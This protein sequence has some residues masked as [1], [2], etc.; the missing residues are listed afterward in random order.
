MIRHTTI[1]RASAFAVGCLFSTH[2][3][4][5]FHLMQIEQVIGGVNGDVTAQAIQLRMRS[6]LQT[7]M[8]LGRLIVYDA[9]G[10][11]PIVV[12][13]FPGTVT[14]STGTRVLVASANFAHYTS[15]AVVPNQPMPA[16]IP[17][18]YLAAGSLT[19]EDAI[20]PG[21]VYWR[22]SWG[23]ASYTGS[24]AGTLDNDADGNFGPAYSGPLPSTSLQS[25][26]FQNNAGDPSTNNA[27]DYLLT[28][29]AAVFN[30]S[31]GGTF[32]VQTPPCNPCNGDLNGDLKVNGDDIAKFA[33]CFVNNSP[34][35]FGCT[36]ADQD[37]NVSFDDTDIS[38]FVDLLLGN[39]VP[40]PPC[41]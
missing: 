30:N 34:G 9:S 13:T 3:F 12:G 5:T 18:S 26:K 21:T 1:V 33:A 39:T 11:N 40:T 16:L 29:G 38:A 24:N 36:C 8:Q 6:A 28:S 23:G 22:V 41:T 35:V 27:A 37:H 31:T 15:P 14:G 7:R 10:N 19:W 4:A 17:A 2:A 32:T 25:L 20:T